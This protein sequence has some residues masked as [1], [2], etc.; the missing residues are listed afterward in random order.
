MG[1]YPFQKDGKP[2]AQ[3]VLR[4]IDP[5]RLAEAE[6]ELKSQLTSRGWL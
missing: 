4:S 3:L 5:A 2:G 6:T 1:S